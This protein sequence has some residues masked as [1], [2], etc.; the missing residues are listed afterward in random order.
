MPAAQAGSGRAG[1]STNRLAVGLA[2]WL[3]PEGQLSVARSARTPRPQAPSI[4]THVVLTTWLLRH[5]HRAILP[6]VRV[7]SVTV[8]LQY[9]PLSDHGWGGGLW[10]DVLYRSIDSGHPPGWQCHGII[11]SRCRH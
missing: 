7:P 6:G 10:Q 3:R 2:H 8:C 11:L 5:L 9:P 4:L 1:V